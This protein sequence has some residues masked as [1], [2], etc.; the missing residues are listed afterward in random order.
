ME[1]VQENVE[2][3]KYMW[4]VSV[5]AQMVLKGKEKI[6]QNK[7]NVVQIGNTVMLRKNV[8]VKMVLLI[9][10]ANVVNV[11]LDLFQHKMV[12]LVY[13]AQIAKYT[14][15]NQIL[16]KIVASK[17]KDGHLINVNAFKNILGGIKNVEYVQIILK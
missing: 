13:V 8:F 12:C 1:D 2:L 14:T 7:S 10:K 5:F 3:I 6:A 11:L 17:I 16:V 15:K 4:I 9:I